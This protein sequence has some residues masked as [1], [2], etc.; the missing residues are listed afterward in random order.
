MST[1]IY[2]SNRYEKAG[3]SSAMSLQLLRSITLAR[4]WWVCDFLT[5]TQSIIHQ[6]KLRKGPTI[7]NC[8]HIFFL[9]TNPKK[10]DLSGSGHTRFCAKTNPATARAT[11]TF[12]R[13]CALEFCA[14][15]FLFFAGAK[16]R[17]SR[18][19]RSP[20]AVEI[21]LPPAHQLIT[22]DLRINTPPTIHH[23]NDG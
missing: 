18:P 22:S 1:Q 7:R 12:L 5:T 13:F 20:G 3:I 10:A 15:E 6:H 2:S 16:I 9:R 4:Q 14:V 8:L 21:W 23:A 19:S 17:P 11:A